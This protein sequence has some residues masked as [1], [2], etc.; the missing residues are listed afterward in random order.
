MSMG[1]NHPP[2]NSTAIM[3]DSMITFMYSP[4]KNSRNGVDEYSVMN[5]ATS[6]DSASSRS[7]G[8]RC[9]SASDEMKK[10]TNMGNSMVK[11]NQPWRCASTMAVRFK[12]PANNS[13]VMMTKPMETSYDP[14]CAAQRSAARKGY[15][16]LDDHPATITP[17]T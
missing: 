7:K 6:S 5:P 4:R 17:Y 3:P 12:D 10:I 14:I 15:L 8:G 16:E 13:T 2:K 1:G 11:A 9:V